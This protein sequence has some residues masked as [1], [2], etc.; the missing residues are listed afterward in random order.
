LLFVCFDK[1]SDEVQS[2]SIFLLLLR[3]NDRAILLQPFSFSSQQPSAAHAA[4][5]RKAIEGIESAV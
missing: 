2:C 5:K 1:V 4:E 3:A